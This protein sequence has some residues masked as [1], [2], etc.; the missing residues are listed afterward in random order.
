MDRTQ[1]GTGVADPDVAPLLTNIDAEWLQKATIEQTDL[2]DDYRELL[3]LVLIFIG[4]VPP[5]GVKFRA[6]GAMHHARWMSKALY[7]LKVWMF[8]DQF[9]LT[10]KEERGLRSVAVFISR[11][12]AKAW[13]EAS[14]AASAPRGDLELLQALNAYHEV[15]DVVAKAALNK[16]KGHLWY[17]SEELVAL[18]LFDTNVPLVTKR[19]ILAAVREKDGKEDAPAKR[20]TLPASA[21]AGR[22]LEDFASKNT[23]LF[24]KKLQLDDEFLEADPE[25]WPE[26]AD[27]AEASAVVH[28]LCVINDHAERGVALVQEYNMILT[29]G[30]E[31][32]QFLLQVVADHR[33]TFPDSRKQTLATPRQ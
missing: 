15:D 33:R 18:A 3:E 26:R 13:T 29:K 2:R 14:L 9:K 7:S 23:R 20:P 5:R 11:V 8:R 32:F 6:P 27:F 17:L 19:K 12:Y 10:V 4:R 31:Q 25:T 30:E 28:G 1:Y 21:I 16:L 22:C 24:F